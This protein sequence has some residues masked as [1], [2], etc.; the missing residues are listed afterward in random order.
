MVCSWTWRY[1][2][3]LCLRPSCG[4]V[5][6][7]RGFHL[8]AMSQ[9]DVLTRGRQEFGAALLLEHKRNVRH[10]CG[11]DQRNTV[12]E[13]RTPPTGGCAQSTFCVCFSTLSPLLHQNVINP[14]SSGHSLRFR[15]NP[16]VTLY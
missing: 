16:T 7:V 14:A 6:R 10:A 5:G 8:L 1:E 11:A 12:A 3:A 13:R 9:P 4:N 2:L 15:S